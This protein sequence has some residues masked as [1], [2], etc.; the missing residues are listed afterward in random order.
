MAVAEGVS[1]GKARTGV[2]VTEGVSGGEARSA[3][4]VG[5]GVSVVGSVSEGVGESEGVGVGTLGN[6]AG[7]KGVICAEDRNETLLSRVRRTPSC[8]VPA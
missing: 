4:A 6:W 3:V 5:V 1:E 2:A 7:S 8:S